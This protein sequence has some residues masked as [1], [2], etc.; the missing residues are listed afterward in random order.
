METERQDPSACDP[1]N[2]PSAP[3]Q[4]TL[5]EEE[6][7]REVRNHKA[8]LDREALGSGNGQQA[9]PQNWTDEDEPVVRRVA[10]VLPELFQR[11]LDRLEDVGGLPE[12]DDEMLVEVRLTITGCSREELS[13]RSISRF[14]DGFSVS[15]NVPKGARVDVG[16]FA[17]DP[18]TGGTDRL[19]FGT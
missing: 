1:Q 4:A 14:I 6:L 2:D 17:V 7:D 11:E 19:D 5:T 13:L 9:A 3:F 10:D 8:M 15:L 12:F 18:D 16:A